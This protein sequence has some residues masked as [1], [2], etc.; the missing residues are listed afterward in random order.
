[1]YTIE[2]IYRAN[3]SNLPFYLTW[4]DSGNHKHYLISNKNPMDGILVEPIEMVMDL[5]IFIVFK[6]L[7]E[8]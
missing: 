3:G 2:E 4:N 7:V 6:D 8:D 1:M 5:R